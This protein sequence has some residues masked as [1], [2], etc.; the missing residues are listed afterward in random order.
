MNVILAPFLRKIFIIF[1]DDILLYSGS[2]DQHTHHLREVLQVLRVHKFFVNLS[3]CAFAQ[4][5]LEYLGHII[6]GARV[7]TDPRKTLAMVQW[8]TPTNVT[9]L[10]GFL[11]LTG[12]YQKFVKNYGLLAKPLTNVLKK[13]QFSWDAAA[14][15]A[16][17]NLKARMTSTPVLALLDF[18]EQFI[19]ETDASDVGLGAVLMQN[20]KPITFLSKPLSLPN[21]FLSIYEKEFL[22]LIMVVEK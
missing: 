22:P 18:S 6:S 11:G 8:P 14:Q 21:K 20:E 12:Y 17:D 16:F 9:E 1:M 10:K 19:V 13:K 7:A 4:A 15:I 3:K 5:E 2:L